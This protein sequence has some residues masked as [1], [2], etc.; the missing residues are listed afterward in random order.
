MCLAPDHCSASALIILFAAI[1][2]LLLIILLFIIL[3]LY[4]PWIDAA[5]GGS[6]PCIAGQNIGGSNPTQS[7]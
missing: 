3:F 4:L 1:A 5:T 6:L 7:T 2:F